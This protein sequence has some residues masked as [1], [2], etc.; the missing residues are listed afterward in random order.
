M[1]R[2][3]HRR[4]APGPAGQ[5]EQFGLFSPCVNEMAVILFF[6][7]R[8]QQRA[9]RSFNGWTRKEAWLKA[10]GRGITTISRPSGSRW[11]PEKSPNCSNCP[12][13]LEP[14]GGGDLRH[15]PASRLCGRG[16]F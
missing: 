3:A 4:A 13:A 8:T 2:I 16:R 15:S 7:P 9:G 11:R 1:T 5:F 12:P 14:R 6:P 10:T